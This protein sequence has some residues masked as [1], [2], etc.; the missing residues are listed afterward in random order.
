[1]GHPAGRPDRTRDAS[2]PVGIGRGRQCKRGRKDKRRRA[3]LCYG[4]LAA[5]PKS[6]HGSLAARPKSVLPHADPDQSQVWEFATTA[7]AELA[8]GH[9]LSHEQN[10]FAILLVGFA[11]QTAELR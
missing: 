10:D 5:K 11:Q 1:M 6:L 9:L 7:V 8:K 3:G 4:S 2:Y